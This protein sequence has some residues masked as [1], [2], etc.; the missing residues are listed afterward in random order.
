M[1]HPGIK[2][3]G[4]FQY[5]PRTFNS[6]MNITQDYRIKHDIGHLV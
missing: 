4:L 1:P 2:D 5:L 3:T 6:L